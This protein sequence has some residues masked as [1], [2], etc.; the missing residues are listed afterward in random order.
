MK[1]HLVETLP[2]ELL[3]YSYSLLQADGVMEAMVLLEELAQQAQ[4]LQMDIF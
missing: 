2:G 4:E 3:F 1:T